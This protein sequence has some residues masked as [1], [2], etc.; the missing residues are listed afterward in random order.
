MTHDIVQKIEEEI[1]QLTLKREDMDR[2]ILQLGK[3]RAALLRLDDPDAPLAKVVEHKPMT[4]GKGK[5][6]G[7][8]QTKH[9]P[10]GDFG[11]LPTGSRNAAMMATVLE[12]LQRGQAHDHSE[13]M[14]TLTPTPLR[15]EVA[16]A[17]RSLE[18]R[19]LIRRTGRTGEPISG[20][21][22]APQRYAVVAPAAPA[23]TGRSHGNG[24]RR[25]AR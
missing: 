16:N 25:T 13:L 9:A 12:A 11:E 23:N 3:A 8:P 5:G 17:L 1:A 4:K 21:G 24:V 15:H 19:G 14:A 22:R 7:K 18:E 20:R 6:K 10:R 2:Q